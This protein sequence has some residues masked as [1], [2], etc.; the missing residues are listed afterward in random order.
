MR[1][2]VTSPPASRPFRFSS[3]QPAFVWNGRLPKPRW[4]AVIVALKD[5]GMRQTLLASLVLAALG[6]SG[7]ASGQY[8]RPCS[9][10]A[11]LAEVEFEALS[12]VIGCGFVGTVEVV[13]R[14]RVIRVLAGPEVGRT[15]LGVIVC[16]G[17]DDVPGARRTMCIGETPPSI[18]DVSRLDRF[19]AD[20]RPRRYMRPAAPS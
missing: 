12:Q 17:D 11:T 9:S 3:Q 14:A 6:S 10:G 15:F 16:A 2:A 13:V 4:V 20:N 5:F 8:G 7:I 1:P 18:Q 19:R